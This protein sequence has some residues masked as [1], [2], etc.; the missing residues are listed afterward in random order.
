MT[1]NDIRAK[2]AKLAEPH[3]EAG[4]ADKLFDFWLNV[5]GETALAKGFDLLASRRG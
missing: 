4:T 5:D 3:Y 1:I 2:F